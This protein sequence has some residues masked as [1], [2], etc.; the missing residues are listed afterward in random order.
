MPEK[1]LPIHETLCDWLLRQTHRDDLIGDL[2]RDFRDDP[3]KQQPGIGLSVF[4]AH[5][6]R[7]RASPEYFV[8][9]DW[10]R[11]EYR[12]YTVALSQL[13]VRARREGRNDDPVSLGARGKPWQRV[14]A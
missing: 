11:R 9:A 12:A 8:A 3:P 1:F 7:R 2:A 10:A 5:M 6:K 4:T 14:H 13:S